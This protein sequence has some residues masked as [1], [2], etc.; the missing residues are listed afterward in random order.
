RVVSV[1]VHIAMRT[2][3]VE[4]D[5]A[6]GEHHEDEYDEISDPSAWLLHRSDDSK[7]GP[8]PLFG[9]C[10][11]RARGLVPLRGRLSPL[12]GPRDGWSFRVYGPLRSVGRAFPW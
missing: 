6:D 10:S 3:L 7:R 8:P 9:N 5:N 11:R 12:L 1:A 2:L 4:A